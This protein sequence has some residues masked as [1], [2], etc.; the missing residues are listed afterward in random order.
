[1]KALKRF[2][3]GLMLLFMYAPI[4][5]LIIYS[6][7]ASKSRAVWAGFTLDWYVALFKDPDIA[8]ALYN[9][10]TIA[11]FSSV[12][13]T[14]IGT[15]AAVGIDAMRG[16]RKTAIMGITNIPVVNPDIVTGVSL[17][18]LYIA[19]FRFIPGLKLGYGTMLLSHVAFNTSYIILSVLPK[20][21]QMDKNLYEA[22]LDLGATPA[23]G[24]F[25]V[26]LPEILPG[27]ITGALLAFTMSLDDFVV[28][29]F[30]TG[31]GVSNLSI[32]IYSMAR[33][34]INPKINA[35]STLMFIAVLL[36]LYLVNLT[37]STKR[38]NTQGLPAFSR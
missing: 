24:F 17:M 26:I 11:F 25:K 38:N 28:S 9:T 1:L 34:G 8:R 15:T 18:I 21:R 16:F 20:L 7:N 2:Y 23:A 35:L 29:F 31:S 33:R 27:I 32:L 3:L 19:I 4:A 36:L 14:V 12:I 13:A 37:D 30:T 5:I 22:A 10:L 6:F